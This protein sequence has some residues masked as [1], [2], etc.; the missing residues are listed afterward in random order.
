MRRMAMNLV[1]NALRYTESGTV[2]VA[3]RNIAGGQSIRLEVWDSGVG[4]SAEHQTDIFKEF[5]QVGNSAR[6]RA[7]G[8]GLGLNI[9]Q[10]SSPLVTLRGVRILLVEDDAFA[11]NAVTG[12]LESWGCQVFAG[13][14]ALAAMAAHEQPSDWDVIL[15]DY[16]LADGDNG[17]MA[18]ARLRAYAGG[19]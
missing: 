11:R 4:I 5:Y 1:H 15:S 14:S 9:V 2:L 17:L 3:C 16:R 19:C 6:D 12:L 7:Y 13:N 8:L 18:I 10:E